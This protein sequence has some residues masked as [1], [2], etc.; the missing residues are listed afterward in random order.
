MST[1]RAWRY[2]RGNQNP[3]IEDE[4]TTQKVK[5]R[6][7]RHT[8]KTKDR[9][10]QTPLTTGGERRC[11]GKISSSCYTSDIR[12]V[13]QATNPVISQEWGKDWEVLTT[14][15][16]YMWSYV[17]QRIH[18]GQPSHGGDLNTFEMT[19]STLLRGTLGSVDFLLTQPFTKEI[20][21]ETTSS[22]ISH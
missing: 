1:R 11:S 20:L 15:G 19:T 12:R 13:N 17:T 18:S 2:Q 21:I 3:Y 14:S 22:G 4:Q 7:T 8:Y 5:Q 6:S 16:K 10:T 9:E